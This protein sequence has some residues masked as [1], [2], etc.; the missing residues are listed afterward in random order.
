MGS[1]ATSPVMARKLRPFDAGSSLKPSAPRR[2]CAS[3]SESPAMPER[4][5]VS[6]G[7]LHVL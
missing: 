6:I 3:L 1:R 2:A 7:P 5:I 4:S